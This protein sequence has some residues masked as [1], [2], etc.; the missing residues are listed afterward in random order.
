[1]INVK[2]I[3]GTMLIYFLLYAMVH[4]ITC[5]NYFIR[6]DEAVPENDNVVLNKKFFFCDREN[7]CTHVVQFEDNGTYQTVNGEKELR[8]INRKTK[9]WK[10]QS[11]KNDSRPSILFTS[12]FYLFISF[13]NRNASVAHKNTMKHA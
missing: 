13:F 7:A 11:R 10:K 6:I 3:A 4:G 9:I 1:M 12:I 5:R 8:M 2:K